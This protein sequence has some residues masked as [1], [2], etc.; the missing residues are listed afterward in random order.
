MRT[1]GGFAAGLTAFGTLGQFLGLTD[2]GHL[3]TYVLTRIVLFL[4]LGT[5]FWMSFS[6][7]ALAW[8]LPQSIAVGGN[9]RSG[10][11]RPESVLTLL[12]MLPMRFWYT[13]IATTVVVLAIVAEL[14]VASQTGAISNSP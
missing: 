9:Q 12:L 14:F 1:A 2:P 13:M 11:R 5:I 6:D 4:V 7:R 8:A 3:G 10:P